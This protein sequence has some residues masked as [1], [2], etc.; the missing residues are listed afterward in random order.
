M[1]RK[2]RRAFVKNARRRGISKS[3]AEAYIAI[4]E[5]GLD[6][7]MLP[8]KIAE[9]DKVLLNVERIQNR[10][11]YEKMSDG[12]K[13]FVSSN[14]GVVFTA[15][16]ERENLISLKESPAWLFWSGDLIKE[17]EETDAEGDVAGAADDTDKRD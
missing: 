9:D 8:S 2:E 13:E 7:P 4:R 10:K 3:T 17:E 6:K 5:A 16:V 12:Y 15:H 11:N 14:A 1:N